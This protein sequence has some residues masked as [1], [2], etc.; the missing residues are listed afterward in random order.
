MLK[1]L[2]AISAVLLGCCHQGLLAALEE[3]YDSARSMCAWNGEGCKDGNETNQYSEHNDDKGVDGWID[4][5][6]GR[7]SETETERSSDW[8]EQVPDEMMEDGNNHG[9]KFHC[10]IL[11]RCCHQGM[12]AAD[13]TRFMC[14]RNGEGCHVKVDTNE[15]SE[16]N[17]NEVVGNGTEIFAYINVWLPKK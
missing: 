10:A 17:E 5:M 2:L 13:S 7:N 6:S 9:K 16:Y 3:D 14:T 11:L 8:I 1:H 12:S 4:T 15:N